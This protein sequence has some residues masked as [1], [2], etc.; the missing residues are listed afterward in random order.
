MNLSAQNEASEIKILSN[1]SDG[2]GEGLHNSQI[3]FLATGRQ[4]KNWGALDGQG[5]WNG[6]QSEHLLLKRGIILA[7]VL[8]HAVFV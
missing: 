1:R 4:C 7:F 2:L 3:Q 5:A 8:K 6:P